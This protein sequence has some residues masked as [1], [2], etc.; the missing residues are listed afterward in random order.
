MTSKKFTIFKFEL[1]SIFNPIYLTF[2]CIFGVISSGA[3]S[4]DSLDF[5]W[6]FVSIDQV[7]L[8]DG[9][10]CLHSANEYKSL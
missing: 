1:I 5:L 7:S 4:S 9:I 2:F 8:R 10:Q 6:P 3:D